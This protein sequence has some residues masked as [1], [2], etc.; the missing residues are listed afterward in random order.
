[1]TLLLLL[2]LQP[3]DLFPAGRSRCP[4]TVAWRP[5]ES[6]TGMV[7]GEVGHLGIGDAQPEEGGPPLPSCS[8]EH[9]RAGHSASEDCGVREH[10][11]PGRRAR[12]RWAAQYAPLGA[13]PFT[14]AEGTYREGRTEQGS[15]WKCP[16]V[17]VRMCAHVSV[18]LVCA[19]MCVCICVYHEELAH[20]IMEAEKFHSLPAWRYK[21]QFTSEGLGM[22][23][24]K[25]S[26]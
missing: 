14:K 8:Q 11:R 7:C 2:G 3:R 16:C 10:E 5:S 15:N 20:V 9:R 24:L 26:V 23:R 13:L 22:R 4:E 6:G 19:Y 25:V 17:Q 12:E 18:C 21:I 1:M